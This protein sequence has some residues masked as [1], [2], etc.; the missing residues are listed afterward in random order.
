M[1][2]V[3]IFTLKINNYMDINLYEYCKEERGF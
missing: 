2:N 3:T 1:D